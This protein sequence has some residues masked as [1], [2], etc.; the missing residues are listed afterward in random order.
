MEGVAHPHQTQICETPS[1]RERGME[2]PGT[3]VQIRHCGCHLRGS[4]G[5]KQQERWMN[6]HG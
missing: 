5:W 3:D 4:D 1:A 6:E 2:E